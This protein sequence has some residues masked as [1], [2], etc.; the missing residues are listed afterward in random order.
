MYHDVPYTIGTI[1][2][3]RGNRHSLQTLL[4]LKLGSRKFSCPSW[5]GSRA[6]E[7][8]RDDTARDAPWMV[9]QGWCIS[10]TKWGAKEHRN[11]QKSQDIEGF[12]FFRISVGGY[13]QISLTSARP[14]KEIASRNTELRTLQCQSHVG[15]FIG[16]HL[17][18]LPEPFQTT[19]AYSTKIPRVSAKS[20]PSKTPEIGSLG[21]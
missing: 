16:K 11:P 20:F 15:K 1:I 14:Q 19:V 17:Q 12:P 13:L 21:F 4:V 2:Q 7:D 10:P 6:L 8:G 18:V 3:T 5:I 9:S